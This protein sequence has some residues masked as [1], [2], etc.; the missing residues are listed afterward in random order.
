MRLNGLCYVVWSGLY[1]LMAYC[2][3]AE[4]DADADERAKARASEIDGAYSKLG[5]ILDAGNAWAIQSRGF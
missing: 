2:T 4:A 1:D 5:S 3:N